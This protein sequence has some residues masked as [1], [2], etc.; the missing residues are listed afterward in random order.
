[1]L[2]DTANQVILRKLKETQKR[3]VKIIDTYNDN[4][5][6]NQIETE[7]ALKQIIAKCR[8]MIDIINNE[9]QQLSQQSY[10]LENTQPDITKEDI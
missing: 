9:K 2:Y 1:M 3:L 10:T 4:N 7:L 8:N 5:P 6:H